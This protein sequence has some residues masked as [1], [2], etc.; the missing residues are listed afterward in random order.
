MTVVNK[1]QLTEVITLDQ[2]FPLKSLFRRRFVPALI[3]FIGIFLVLIGFT[4]KQTVES[5]YLELAQR[6]AQTIARALAEHAPVAWDALMSGKMASDLASSA[7]A[8][9]LTKAFGDEVKALNLLE[10][11]IYDLERIVLYA[12]HP[13]EIGSTENGDALRNVIKRL[14]PGIVTK[15]IAD[16]SEQYELYVPVFDSAGTLRSVFELY[17]PVGYLNAILLRAAIPIVGFSGLLLLL[18]GLALNKLVN[19]A[20]ADIDLRTTAINVLRRRIE[21]FVSST[22]VNAAKSAD[23]SGEIPSRAITTTLFFSDIRDFTGFAEQNTPQVVVDFL[24]DLMTLQVD[25]LKKFGGDVDKMIGDAILARFDGADA[26]ARALAAAREILKAVK[27][28]SY[29]RSIGIGVYEGE[30]I[31]GAIGPEDR[32]DFTVIGDTVNIAARLCAAAGAG[33]LVTD[34]KIANNDFG[35]AESIHVKGRQQAL[36]VRRWTPPSLQAS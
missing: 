34:A 17:E 22:A 12:T 29:P 32:R 3:G 9:A 28:G 30:V 11:K 35:S 13:E 23:A 21:S 10:L 24:N 18:L 8:E 6:R 19:R 14:T 2:P 27:H 20:Q 33:E 1:K 36:S 4:N 7:D 31:S 25:K 5:I 26:N 15:P 16:G